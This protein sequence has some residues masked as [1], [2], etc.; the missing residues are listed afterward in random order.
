[1]MRA[2]NCQRASQCGP[3]KRSAQGDDKHQTAS[4]AVTDN[5][6]RLRTSDA[7]LRIGP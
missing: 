2:G 7:Q 6:R 3:L 1:M 4:Y 5:C